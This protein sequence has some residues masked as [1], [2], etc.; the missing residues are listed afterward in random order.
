MDSGATTSQARNERFVTRHT[1][2]PQSYSWVCFNNAVA[3]RGLGPLLRKCVVSNVLP[4]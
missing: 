1:S 4:T 2:T 3:E